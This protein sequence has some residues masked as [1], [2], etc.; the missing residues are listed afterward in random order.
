MTIIE[1][2][3]DSFHS[4]MTLRLRPHEILLHRIL[5]AKIEVIYKSFDKE[6]LDS[7]SL[8][9]HLL[10]VEIHLKN[11]TI[12]KHIKDVRLHAPVTR[13]KLVIPIYFID[14]SEFITGQYI[15]SSAERI[16][17]K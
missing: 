2:P 8:Q 13:I 3:I 7:I 6:V 15:R 4:C 17:T 11:S 12:C 16:N 5:N 10:T 14:H 1:S 9:V